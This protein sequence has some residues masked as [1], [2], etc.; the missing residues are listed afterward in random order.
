MASE[1]EQ[2]IID[3]RPYANKTQLLSRGIVPEGVYDKIR[4]LVIA[5]Q[6]PLP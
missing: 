1:A 2:R 5:R 3:G 6:T 4:E